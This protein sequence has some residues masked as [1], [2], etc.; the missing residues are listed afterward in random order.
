MIGGEA[1]RA[2]LRLAI[3]LVLLSGI[4]VVLSDRSSAEAVVAVM[5]LAVSLLF[6]AA[7]LGLARWGTS[8]IPPRRDNNGSKG[9]N[10]TRSGG[11]GPGTAT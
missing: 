6:L 7:V 4:T 2:A 1:T 3:L 8:R 10:D 9:Y 11:R 5:A